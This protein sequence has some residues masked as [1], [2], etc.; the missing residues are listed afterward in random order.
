M[1]IVYMKQKSDTIYYRFEYSI[2]TI[3]F[4]LMVVLATSNSRSWALGHRVWGILEWW[5]TNSIKKQ[6]SYCFR[7]TATKE[8]SNIKTLIK[9]KG[10][11]QKTKVRN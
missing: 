4:L 2:R 10:I 8:I 7:K 9:A 11:V 6:L 3:K 5:T 1:W